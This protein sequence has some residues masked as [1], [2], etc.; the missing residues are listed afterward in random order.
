MLGGDYAAA[1]RILKP[2]AD[3]AARP[4]PV[5]Q[6]FLAILYD[7]GHGVPPDPLRACG[8]F[9]AASDKAH[10][11]SHQSAAFATAMREQLGEGA[12]FC[13][14]DT[15]QGGAPL[16][17]SLGPDH[18]VVFADTS[19]TVTHAG[20][21]QRMMHML[22]PGAMALPIQHTPL[23]VTRPAAMRR[24]FFQ[25]FYWIP[26]RALKPS[27]WR[28]G[29]I[30]SEVASDTWIGLAGEDGLLVVQGSTRPG[31]EDV[32]KLVRVQVNAQGEAEFA[33]VG[34]PSPRTEPIPWH[35][36]R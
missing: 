11:F 31:L 2:L 29:W 25:W 17:F 20:K 19:I 15:W 8:L 13:A 22:P 6:F 34:G 7:T 33:I 3:N 36:G 18:R 21:E 26:D 32:S 1:V 14:A 28:L 35:G 24:D 5:A 12:R 16:S 23:T 27:S 4:D 30:L 10:P 9:L